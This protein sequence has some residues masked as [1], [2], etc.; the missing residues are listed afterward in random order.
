MH[1]KISA[2]SRLPA[3]YWRFWLATGL[4]NI[5]N[6]TYV[7]AVPLLAVTITHDPRLVTGI[8]AATYL[9]WLLLSLPA[10]T[11]V[12]RSARISLMWRTQLAAAAIVAGATVL[13]AVGRINIVTL[14]ALA[15]ALGACDVVV[16]NAAQ[17]VLPELV[18]KR[19]LHRANGHQ[20]AT[21]TAGQQFAGPPVGSGLF[22]VSAA[23]PFGVN[24]GSFL[25]SAC[26]LATLPKG[27]PAGHQCQPMRTA[28]ASGFRWLMRHR[29]LR[30][31]AVLLGLN[32]FCG[33][34]ANATLVLLA[35]QT[36]RVEVRD[37]GLLLASA[38][39]GAV[40][41]AIVNARIVQRIGPMPALVTALALNVVALLGAG[42][43]PNALTLGGSLAVN[44]FATTMWNIVTTTL[45]QELVPSTMLG[46]VTSIYKM[47][48]W[49]LIPLGALTGGLVAH[50]LGLRA[51]YQLAGAL[52]GI[53]LVAALPVLIPA[54][55]ATNA[56]LAAGRGKEPRRAVRG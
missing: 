23:L 22:A 37:Y 40:L 10:G 14:A 15:F 16:G 8:S 13:V 17:A 53:A 49:G 1:A 55:R 52:R 26:L 12:D 18:P 2:A 20:Q 36:L 11:I 9:P 7:A 51:P 5:G 46:R 34:M 44:G 47:L 35:T 30:A 27:G 33:H 28:I 48:G 42:Y 41:G 56:K 24:A 38:A 39:L 3:A 45:R 29:L 25:L 54:M 31:L 4:D 32:T 19:L 21:I 43:S 50:Q 6:G